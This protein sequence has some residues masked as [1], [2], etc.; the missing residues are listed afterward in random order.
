ME[1][2]RKNANW[3]LYFMGSNFTGLEMDL[4]SKSVI[5]TLKP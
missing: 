4:C 2:T 1:E 5:T 3:K